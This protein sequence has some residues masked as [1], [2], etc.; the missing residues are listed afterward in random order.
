M[1]S[2]REWYITAWNNDDDY[3]TTWSTISNMALAKDI[4]KTYL[5]HYNHVELIEQYTSQTVIES[6]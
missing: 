4:Y 1:E 3:R 2:H 6:K 5:K